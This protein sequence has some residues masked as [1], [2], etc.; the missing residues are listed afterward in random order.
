MPYIILKWAETEDGF[1]ARKDGSSKWISNELSR[2]LV[3]KWRSEEAGIL[4]GV[5]TANI[6]N[7]SLNVRSW[8][9]RDPVRIVLDP[10]QKLKSKTK[11]LK[12]KGAVLIYNKEKNKKTNN[13]NFI[14]NKSFELRHILRDILEKGIGS[15]I[16]EGGAKTLNN[17]IKEGLW[18][19]ARVFVSNKKFKEGIKAPKFDIHQYEKIRDNKLYT[20]FNHA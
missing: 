3:H 8:K 4:V 6:D 9:G 19:E 13:K 15:L 1:I 12:D 17:F 5:N 20:I 10:N 14:Q 2:M 18:D 11:L 16:V 7:P